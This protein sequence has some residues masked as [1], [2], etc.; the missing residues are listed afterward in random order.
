MILNLI[1]NSLDS[2]FDPIK[3]N[4]I[5]NDVVPNLNINFYDISYT[6]E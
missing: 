3:L 6:K 4:L 2:D 1:Y 5:D